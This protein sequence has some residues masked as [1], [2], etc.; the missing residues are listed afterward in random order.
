MKNPTRVIA[1]F[2]GLVLTGT[3]VARAQTPSP[4]SKMFASIS[5]GAQVQSHTFSD[6]TN[7]T[8]FNEPASVSANQTIGRGGLID[9]GVGRRLGDHWAV[10]VGLWGT[11]AK[12]TASALADL[13]DPIVFGHPVTFAATIPDLKQTAIGVN[14]QLIWTTAINDKIDFSVFV[15]PTLLHVSQEIGTVTAVA[16]TQNAVATTTSESKTGMKGG[17]AGIDVSYKLNDRYGAGVFARWAG[18]EV[19]LPSAP[20]VKA[21][22]AQIGIGLRVRY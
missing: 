15:G 2:V 19:D 14:F 17:N 9:L 10:G 13:P 16:N 22:G 4:D 6:S 8:L 21:G 7:F 20:H 3:S 5:L 18:G 11:R 12:G 1:L